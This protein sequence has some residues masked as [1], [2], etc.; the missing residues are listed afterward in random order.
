M[1]QLSIS[2]IFVI[3]IVLY[4][5]LFNP[6]FVFFPISPMKCMYP[7]ILGL[8]IFRRNEFSF[9]EIK[10]E[11]IIWG[12]VIVYSFFMN[13]FISNRNGDS[14]SILMDNIFSLFE[15]VFLPYIVARYLKNRLSLN[16]FNKLIQSL[17]L[18]AAISTIICV[19]SPSFNDYVKFRL[20]KVS[21]S[22]EHLSLLNFRGF[23]ISNE[24]FFG[25]ACAMGLIFAYFFNSSKNIGSLLLLL[26]APICVLVNARIGFVFVA[27]T[28]LLG[29]F[30]N[31]KFSLKYIQLFV[32]IA[33]VFASSVLFSRFAGIIDYVMEAVYDTKDLQHGELSG[34][35]YAL[36][37]TMVIWPQT[38]EHWIFGSGVN[39]YS[40]SSLIRTDIG[41][42][43]QLNYG[44][45]IY[46]SLLIYFF[47]IV[48]NKFKKRNYVF[49]LIATVSILVVNW[50]G[51]TLCSNAC[52]K[53][54]MLLYFYN[55]L[56]RDY[57]R[58]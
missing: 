16:E 3:F 33:I 12:G 37:D 7:I 54:Y 55:I 51:A 25:Y 34:N 56:D 27:L 42:I 15:M 17:F 48:F 26:L 32:I 1:K 13:L 36:L 11:S 23:G 5:F 57:I 8:L 47:V 43:Q 14:G 58:Q 35:Y 4:L 39:L 44:G 40:Y 46:C 50:K 30:N 9:S 29:I 31:I 2:Q 18:V 52:I 28:L 53:I 49:A 6:N 41:Y 24:L 10:R 45:L 19:L 21:D 20:F 22:Y 38:L